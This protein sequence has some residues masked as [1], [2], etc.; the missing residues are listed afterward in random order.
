M[1]LPGA[2]RAYVDINKV[3]DYCLGSSHPEGRH[4]ARVFRSA[5]DLSAKDAEYL[6]RAILNAVAGADAVRGK[7]D[8]YGSR[9]VVDLKSERGARH[10]TIRTVWIVRRNEDFPRLLTCYVL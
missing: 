1:K 3:R 2:E 10:A 7:S 9:Y 8:A 6:R 5:L 4:K